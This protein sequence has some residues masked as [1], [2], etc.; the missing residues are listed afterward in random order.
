MSFQPTRKEK[1][2]TKLFD[3]NRNYTLDDSELLVIGDREKLGQ[4]R[5]KGYGPP[6]FKLGR[7][8]VYRGSDLNAWALANRVD[9]QQGGEC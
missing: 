6:Y 4:W 8:I 3:D 5:H 2:M 9:H 1:G 7:K